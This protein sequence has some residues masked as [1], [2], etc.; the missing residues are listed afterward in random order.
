QGRTDVYAQSD[1]LSGDTV[2]AL[3]EDREGN[4]W[5]ATWNG[6][7]RFR[8]F[9]VATFTVNQGLS[10]SIVGSVLAARDGSV[11]LGARDG[12]NRWNDGQITIY[13]K[14]S[15]Q[16]QLG[17]NTTTGSDKRDGKLNGLP[18]N[19]LFQDDRGRI[20]A[21]TLREFGYLENDRFISISAVPGGV[22]HSI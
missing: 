13:G 3:F 11:W 2:S 9:A 1:G 10:N 22:V 12:L 20:W 17:T 21:S 6:L 19:S 18:P 16:A 7:D 4:V 15:S 14:R 5:V 8:E